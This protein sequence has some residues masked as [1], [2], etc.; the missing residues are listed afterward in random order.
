MFQGAV[1]SAVTHGNARGNGSGYTVLCVTRLHL[2]AVTHPVTGPVTAC[3]LY[4][5]CHLLIPALLPQ[6]LASAQQKKSSQTIADSTWC[7]SIS[8]AWGLHI[9]YSRN[10]CA[11][12]THYIHHG[13]PCESEYVH[14]EPVFKVVWHKVL[15]KVP[16]KIPKG[17][18]RWDQTTSS[19]NHESIHDAISYNKGE[20]CTPP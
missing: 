3:N 4:F 8:C 10:K 1:T 16:L 2:S 7:Q 9:V 14:P 17:C 20:D 13:S 6:Q 19:T 11:C 18:L 15:N 12:G 5:F